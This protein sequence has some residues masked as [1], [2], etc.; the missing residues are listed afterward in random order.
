[1]DNSFKELLHKYNSGTCTPQEQAIIEAWYQ[2]ME[3]ADLAPVTEEQLNNIAGLKLVI[4][5]NAKVRRLSAWLS[6]A[7]A[8]ILM[9]G[10]AS[11]FLYKAAPHVQQTVKLHNDA[12]PGSNK[13]VLTL[14]NGHKIFLGGVQNG[15]IAHQGEAVVEKKAD[16]ELSYKT[17]EPAP[18]RVNMPTVF[19]SVST[20]RGGQHH[21]ILSDGTGVWLNASSSIKY[22]TVFNGPERR[23]EI[24]GEAYFEVAHNADKPFKVTCGEQTVEVLGTH[25]NINAYA[26]EPL[27]N[28]TLLQGLV[29]VSAGTNMALLKPGEQSLVS[30]A[31]NIK[32]TQADVEAA[33]DW[34][35]GDFVFKSQTLPAIM[36]KLARWYDV[37]INYG[38]Y[39][40]SK[41]TF[42][43]VVSRSRNLSAVLKM[44]ESSATVKFT[45]HDKVLTI[46]NK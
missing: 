40:N 24:T 43:G 5:G 22:P 44:L 41:L 25:F 6:A 3:A 23:I 17:D 20:P 34:K 14:A 30:S 10:A 7:A 31:N 12:L 1:M 11:Y 15:P 42:S 18:A 36:R 13:A 8:V 9:A 38:S 26:D 39:S 27:I 21:L 46:V 45:V 33:V 35:E 28:T 32:V 16:G 37:D 2:Q 19:N 29:R 4:P